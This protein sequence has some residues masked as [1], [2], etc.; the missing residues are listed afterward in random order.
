MSDE[1]LI[2]S[3]HSLG[4]GCVCGVLASEELESA[5]HTFDRAFDDAGKS[6]LAPNTR[7][8]LSGEVLLDYPEFARLFVHPRLL[9][10]IAKV[11]AEAMPWLWMIR[12]NRYTPPHSGVGAHSD[13]FPGEL[14]PPLHAWR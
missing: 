14:A 5:R 10:V 2:A 9:K 6:E 11:L 8:T 1:N 12:A 13:A 3:V 4:V 7:A